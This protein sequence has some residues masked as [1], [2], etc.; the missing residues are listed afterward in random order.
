MR[1]E[2]KNLAAEHTDG[3]VEDTLVFVGYARLPAGI[4]GAANSV[5]GLE[6][7]VRAESDEVV[8]A[9]CSL[10]SPL[11]NHLLRRILIGHRLSEGVAKPGQQILRRY[12]GSD[13]R[14]LITALENAYKA[15]LKY[16]HARG[17]GEPSLLPLNNNSAA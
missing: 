4:P 17:K 11:V 7:E 12:F 3:A 13:R 10:G 5:I 8:G 15:Y 2:G 1:L 14:A 9:F 6:I 16:T